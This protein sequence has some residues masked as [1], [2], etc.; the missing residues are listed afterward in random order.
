MTTSTTYTEKRN[1]HRS[2]SSSVGKFW[3]RVADKYSRQPIANEDAYRHKLA[4]TQDY[5]TEDSLV[6]EIGCGT[7]STALK[8]APLVKEIIATDVSGRMIEIAQDRADASG[9]GNVRFLQAVASK[10]LASHETYDAV[11]ALNLLHLLPDWRA[12]VSKARGALKPGGVFV[13]STLCL[14]E[15][16]A[17]LRY[18]APIGRRLGLMPEL[19][20]FRRSELKSAL[21]L[22]GFEIEYEWQADARNGLFLIARKSQ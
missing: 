10:A 11:L 18:V 21:R 17:W 13:T 6:L 22:D 20:H 4:R 2:P 7:G 5:L 14:S 1:T 12:V 3:D 19:V 9:V 16:F 15:Q 8:H